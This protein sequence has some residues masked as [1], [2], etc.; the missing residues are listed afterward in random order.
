[1]ANFYKG[2]IL[3]IRRFYLPLFSLLF[4]LHSS[5]QDSGISQDYALPF[6]YISKNNP[7][8]KVAQGN[9]AKICFL[10]ASYFTDPICK[11]H[12]FFRYFQI[13]EAMHPNDYPIQRVSRKTF[14]CLGIIS[15]APIAAITTPIGV[16]LRFVGLQTQKTPF[17]YLKGEG[18]DKGLSLKQSFSLLS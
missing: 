5:A 15:C 8:Q 7:S 3:A 17:I 13:V 6:L 10:A 18:K 1:M 4:F 16:A 2:I 9:V 12:E 14:L 11:S